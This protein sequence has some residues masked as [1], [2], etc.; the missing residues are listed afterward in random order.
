VPQKDF[1]HELGLL[2]AKNNLPLQF[3]ESV[4]FKHLI[5]HLSLRV[6]LL[7]RKQFSQE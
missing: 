4:W 6:V 1:L 3:I 7:S 5:S 2:I